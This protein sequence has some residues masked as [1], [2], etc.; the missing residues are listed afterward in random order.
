[1]QSIPQ[2]VLLQ[3][4]KHKMAKVVW[5][6]LKTR[7]VGADRV[8]QARLHTLKSEFESQRM[9]QSESID[10]FAGKLSVM[11]SRYISLGATM[12]DST[13]VKKL[14]DSVLNKF[15]PVVAGI[16]QFYDVA[17]RQ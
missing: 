17:R 4:V 13:M 14:L 12:E 10:D 2:D 3:V 6:S 16:E 9:K 7:Y 11:A 5:D 8:K 15:F 1:M